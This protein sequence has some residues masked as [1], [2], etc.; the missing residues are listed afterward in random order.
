MRRSIMTEPTSD[1]VKSNRVFVVFE[2]LTAAE[3]DDL[4]SEAVASARSIGMTLDPDA[5]MARPMSEWR[6][7]FGTKFKR[8]DDGYVYFID[9]SA[10]TRL[11]VDLTAV[12]DF[13]ETTLV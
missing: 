12:A 13:P 9:P 6:T 8:D 10:G 7:I 2:E 4:Q 1:F 3:A 5:R 11:K